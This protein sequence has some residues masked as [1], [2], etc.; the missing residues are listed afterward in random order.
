[1]SL[2]WH[3]GGAYLTP[4]SFYCFWVASLSSEELAPGC[5]MVR[6]QADR[7]SVM[8]W[9]IL[10]WKILCPVMSVDAALALLSQQV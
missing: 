6:R 4:F 1:M 7:G 5:T 3:L 8:I 9:A 10:C 2:Q